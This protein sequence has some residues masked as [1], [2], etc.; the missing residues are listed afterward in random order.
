MTCP[1]RAG[2]RVVVLLASNGKVRKAAYNGEVKTGLSHPPAGGGSKV[3]IIPWEVGS[4]IDFIVKFSKKQKSILVGTI[5]GDAYLQKTG[6]KNARLRLEHSGKQKDYLFWKVGQFPKLFQGEPKYLERKHPLSGQIYKYWRHQ[7]NSTPELGKWHAKFYEG[8]KKHIPDDL[9]DLLQDPLGLAVWYMD[10]GYY[11]PRDKVSYL[12]L[13]RVSK[14]EAEIANI[15]IGKNF[16]IFS[17]VLDKKQKGFALYF[18]Y[19]ESKKL[20]ETIGQFVLPSMRY[21][22]I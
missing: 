12:Y 19:N 20:H 10:D 5:L 22:L 15:A 6:K 11:Y 18:S 2:I 1:P 17:K 9:I 3:F 21:K 14:S 13:G 7:S 8:G 4:L 16:N